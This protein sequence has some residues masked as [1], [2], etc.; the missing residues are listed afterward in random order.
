VFVLL[1][2][3]AILDFGLAILLVA[4]SGFIIGGGP[5]S[6]SNFASTAAWAGALAACLAAP[7]AGFILRRRGFAGAG[8]TVAL[9]PVLV[10]LILAFGP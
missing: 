6:L 7:V 5:E 1:V 9:V 10:G 3:A 8:T 4:V 2:I